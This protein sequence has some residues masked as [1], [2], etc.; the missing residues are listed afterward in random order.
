MST[1]PGVT[2]RQ[3]SSTAEWPSASLAL[4]SSRKSAQ[5][6]KSSPVGVPSSTMILRRPG[7]SPST[8]SHLARSA[9]PPS[10]AYLAPTSLA[11]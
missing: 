2:A 7:T 11:T 4:P 5:L 8:G 1:S 6:M 3:R 9:A 10:T